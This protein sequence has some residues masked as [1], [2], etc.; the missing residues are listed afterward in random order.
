M[1]DYFFPRPG[2]QYLLSVAEIKHLQSQ[3]TVVVDDQRLIKAMAYEINEGL[4]SGQIVTESTSAHVV[5]YR[6]DERLTSFTVYDDASAETEDK[7][8]LWYRE[9]LQ[10]MRMLTSQI[11]PFELRMQ[12]ATNL[13]DL[14]YR[15]RLYHKA[16]KIR[17]EDSSGENQIVYPAVDE[18][19][20]V[21]VRAYQIVGPKNSIMREHKCPSAGEGKCHYAINPNCK[22]DSLRDMVL[23][24]ETKG[25]WNQHGGPELFTFD[26]H[27]PKGGCVLLNDGTVKFIRTK[28]EL[29]QLRWK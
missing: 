10:S 2:Q 22:R 13:R 28:E 16:E 21:M 25:G 20:D 9:S 7:Q 5:C 19:C 6:G 8:C 27:D 29:Q 18:W 4:C 1:L 15:L 3:K 14:W 12:C 17:L 23:L 11:Q 26:N 24:F